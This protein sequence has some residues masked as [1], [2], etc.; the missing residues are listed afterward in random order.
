[1]LTADPGTAIPAVFEGQG[2]AGTWSSALHD[3]L[4][5]ALGLE[6]DTV[7]LIPVPGH[8]HTGGSWNPFLRDQGPDIRR[9][10]GGDERRGQS[11]RTRSFVNPGQSA[12]FRTHPRAGQRPGSG[13]L[14]LTGDRHHRPERASRTSTG[15]AGSVRWPM[16]VWP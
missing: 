6:P 11:G 3:V 1:M 9:E 4:G 10:A 14:R 13:D 5:A 8:Q 7:V 2:V 16:D 15:L 12:D